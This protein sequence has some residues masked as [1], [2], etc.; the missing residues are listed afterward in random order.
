M[1]E[2][3][4][5]AEVS[6]VSEVVLSKDA[7]IGYADVIYPVPS[8]EIADEAREELADIAAHRRGRRPAGRVLRRD[9]RRG[10]PARVRVDGHDRRLLRARDHARLAAGR[11]HAADHRRL[12]RRDRDHGPDRALGRDRALRDRADPGHD[13]RPGG[14]HRL[15]AV[16]PRPPQAEPRRRH[17]RARVGRAGQRHRRQRRRV[18][19]HDRR[20]RARRPARHQ[21]PVPLRHG[22][23]RGRHRDDR[24][25]D[26]DHAAARRVRLLRVA[27]R[28]LQPPAGRRAASRKRTPVSAR[29]VGFVTRHPD[30]RAA[31]RPGAADRVRDPRHAHDRSACRTVPRSR[32]RRPSAAP[33]TC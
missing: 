8:G 28:A 1:A 19:R 12:R 16:H 29:W 15:C 10:G 24:G 14:R 7:T 2:A 18:R 30:R 17:G 4:G 11:G 9:R 25:P 13:A 23:G 32:P 6:G 33:T 27:A 21:H 31:H 3:K 5:A 26:R 22:P 20:D